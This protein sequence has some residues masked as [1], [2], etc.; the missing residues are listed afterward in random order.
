MKRDRASRIEGF[1]TDVQSYE[2]L[3]EQLLFSPQ[4]LSKSDRQMVGFAN[5]Q[6]SYVARIASIHS[7]SETSSPTPPQIDTFRYK[8]KRGKTSTK[9]VESWRWKAQ[10]SSVIFFLHTTSPSNKLTTRSFFTP[11]V[12]NNKRDGASTELHYRVALHQKDRSRFPCFTT[13]LVLINIFIL[14]HIYSLLYSKLTNVQT[15]GRSAKLLRG[16]GSQRTTCCIVFE[17]LDWPVSE[18]DQKKNGGRPEPGKP[19]K[20]KPEKPKPEREGDK[21]KRKGKSPRTQQLV[22]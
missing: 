9:V 19:E 15:Y 4:L 6:A 14:S 11:T 20:P 8:D 1:T 10:A 22:S 2:A 16:I 7:L 21:G 3:R 5:H 18:G 12:H 17:V 13:G